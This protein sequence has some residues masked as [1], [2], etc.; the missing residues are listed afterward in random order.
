MDKGQRSVRIRKVDLRLLIAGFISLLNYGLILFVNCI[1][2]A[3][4]LSV[5]IPYTYFSY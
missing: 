3:K 1:Y 2:L 5:D 4:F